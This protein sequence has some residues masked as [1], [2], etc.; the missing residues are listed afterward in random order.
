[1]K[2]PLRIAL[3][4]VAAT[5]VLTGVV[6][7]GIKAVFPRDE[8]L[9]AGAF[10]V[11]TNGAYYSEAKYSL[12]S[13]L[14]EGFVQTGEIRETSRAVFGSRP[15]QEGDAWGCTKGMPIYTSSEEPDVVY[16]KSEKRDPKADC[17]VRFE[18]VK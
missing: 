18:R 6:W 17:Y 2:K 15:M 13:Q 1:M 10:F 7:I 14:P 9:D 3:I 4:C 5:L 11:Y 12:Y 8:I 16:V